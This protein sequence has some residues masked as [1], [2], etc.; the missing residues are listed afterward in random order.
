MCQCTA[1]H[2]VRK[3]Y[4]NMTSKLVS[5]VSYRCKHMQKA[6]VTNHMV[7]ALDEYT[8]NQVEKWGS[9]AVFVRLSG[10]EEEQAL[11]SGSNHAVSGKHATL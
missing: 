6:G 11:K 4:V 5:Y 7:V 3:H 9:V 10:Q 1:V 8:K 2:E